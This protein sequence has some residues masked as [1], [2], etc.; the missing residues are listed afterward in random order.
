M[1]IAI[2]GATGR[3]GRA[4]ARLAGEADDWQI[5]GASAAGEDPLLG[6]DVGEIAG[7]GNVGVAVSPDVGGSL[8]GADVVVDFSIAAAVPNLLNLAA[9]QGVAVV[10]GTTN[11]GDAERAALERAAE[12]I[13]VMWAQNMSLGVQ[14]L[15]ELVTEAVRRLG[16]GF[17]AEIVEVHHRNKVDSP[18]GT[19]KRLATA[20]R[21]AR[22]D[23][24]ELHAREGL[25]GAR[26]DDEVGVFGVRGGD[27][28]GDHTVHLFGPG[29]RI[30][31]THRASNR[32]LFAH[33]AIRAARFL[34]TQKPGMYAIAD[35]LRG[36]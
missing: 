2:H 15:A 32:D 34:P 31:L 27:V 9:K 18:S 5:V 10:S 7:C 17:D 12:K 26:T 30:E 33:G 24:R 25:V 16:S 8:L 20:V 35:V 11:I 14:V 1:K 21:E 4:V 22:P 29:E 13:P 19:A 23:I 36:K 3:M 6:Q 28:I